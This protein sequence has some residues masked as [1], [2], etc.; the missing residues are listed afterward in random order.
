MLFSRLTFWSRPGKL[1]PSI[2]R[3][4]RSRRSLFESL[5][6]R[7]L[8]TGTPYE[9]DAAVVG[10]MATTEVDTHPAD[11]TTQ[12]ADLVLVDSKASEYFELQTVRDA[13]HPAARIDEDSLYITSGRALKLMTAGFNPL[14]A[15]LYWIRTIQ[16]YGRTKLKTRDSTAAPGP[17]TDYHLL[18]PLLD[19]TTTLDPRYNIAYR[20]GSIFLAEAY[21]G[22]PGRPDLPAAGPE[23]R[24]RS[25]GLHRGGHVA[26][27]R[28]GG[29]V[30]LP[31]G[32]GPGLL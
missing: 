8:L 24:R 3:S 28:H 7:R 12:V 2:R 31:G 17:E 4:V 6:D 18:H 26:V 23:R 14:A 16:Y 13:G 27:G 10:M 11:T 29:R 30:V 5:E 20:F 1:R 15:D 21:P 19:L 22:G 32:L 9:E 25:P